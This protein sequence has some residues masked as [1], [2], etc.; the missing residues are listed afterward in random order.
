MWTAVSLQFAHAGSCY[1]VRCEDAECEFATFIDVSGGFTFKQIQ[2]YCSHCNKVVYISWSRPIKGINAPR[3]ITESWD[4]VL[5][6]V[7]VK[8]KKPGPDPIT[9]FWD[10]I[11]G[12]LRQVYKCSECE[13][14]FVDIESIDEFHSCPKCG[15]PTLNHEMILQYD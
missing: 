7:Q 1:E 12:E 10:P 6:S 11:T 14:P 3:P 8:K 5:R 15:K 9:E 2:G 13:L 4:P